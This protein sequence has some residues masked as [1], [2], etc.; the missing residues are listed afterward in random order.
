M[1]G[2]DKASR[3]GGSD[4]SPPTA[5]LDWAEQA[6]ATREVLAELG[7]RRRA[8]VVRRG[9]AIGALA[10]VAFGVFSLSR[11]TSHELL[12]QAPVTATPTIS[13]AVVPPVESNPAPEGRTLVL[14]DGSIVELKARAEVEV[15]FSGALRRVR[16][17]RGM[18]FFD[19]AKDPARPFVVTAEGLEVR[20]VGTAFAVQLAAQKVEVLVTE[21]RVRVDRPLEP[22]G[23]APPALQP[24][25]MMEAGEALVVDLKPEAGPLPEILPLGVPALQARLDWRAPTVEFSATPLSEVVAVVNR[26]ARQPLVLAE[27]ELGRLRIS[28]FMRADNT[29]A[30]LRLIEL[31]LGLVAEQRA[32]GATLLRARP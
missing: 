18:A 32:D 2:V 29:T 11:P 10:A 28:G 8:R 15:D 16:L 23:S 4:S 31:E 14:A 1:K 25:A 13:V 26:H 24:V 21:G 22:E 12:P 6:G 20:A 17:K 19:V 5:T 7:R 27:P 3:E 9:A 30:L